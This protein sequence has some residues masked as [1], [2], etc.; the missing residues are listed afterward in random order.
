MLSI[1]IFTPIFDTF[2]P[3]TPPLLKPQPLPPPS[4]S[5]H[6][7]AASRHGCNKMS[8]STSSFVPPCRCHTLVLPSA[9]RSRS[10]QSPPMWPFVVTTFFRHVVAATSG[11]NDV[12]LFLSETLVLV[13]C[14]PG[15]SVV[16]ARDNSHLKSWHQDQETSHFPSQPR[17]CSIYHL[18]THMPTPAWAVLVRLKS[19]GLRLSQHWLGGDP[20]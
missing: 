11:R 17:S 8:Y 3:S 13:H 10:H 5:S 6:P 15:S 1:N 9:A 2:L 19:H 7:T 14:H 20:G 18:P 16:V 12:T 4:S